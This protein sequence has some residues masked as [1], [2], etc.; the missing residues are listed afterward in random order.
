LPAHCW[1]AA[2]GDQRAAS[3]ARQERP[4]SDH[5]APR[6]RGVVGEGGLE[7]PAPCSQSRCATTAPLPVGKPGGCSHFYA[8]PEGAS[9]VRPALRAL[10]VA[11]PLDSVAYMRAVVEPLEG[12]KVKLSIEVD[13]QEFEKDIDAA[14]RQ[15]A[16]EV[17]IPGFRPGKAPRRILE[18]RLG[19]AA[20]RSEALRQA[21]PTYYSKAI[22]EHDVDVVAAPQIEITAGQD[23][24][25]VVFDAVVEVRPHVAVTGYEALRVTIPSPV[26]TPEDVEA[27]IDRLRANFAELQEVSRP[28]RAGDFVSLN[29]Q[30]T[31]NEE[32]VAGLSADDFLYEIGSG[33]LLPQLDEKLPGVRIGDILDFEA[34]LPD[35][36]PGGP[37]RMKVLV[38][39]V[40][41]RK[42]PDLDDE[43]ASEASEFD[44]VE[45]LR[46]DI[47]KRTAVMK[48][49]QAAMA[50]RNAVVE[51]LVEL[52]KE[53]P[54]ET[55]V[56]AEVER[57]AHDLVHRLER[58]GNDVSEYLAATGQS[59]QELLEG[60]RARA[61]PAV[62]ADLALRAVAEAEG[63][64]PTEEDLEAELQRLAGSYGVSAVELRAS[65]ERSD[66]MP[67]L[68][69]DWKKAK[70]L[71]WLVEHV[72]VVDEAGNPI[73][74]A[75]LVLDD[76]QTD[77]GETSQSEAGSQGADDSP[78]AEASEPEQRQDPTSEAEEAQK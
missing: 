65:L 32:P 69:S 1:Q 3:E 19:K 66:Q 5:G 60:F 33:S 54:P 11:L 61:I 15:I 26:A 49:L 45:E 38:K 24:G 31:Q 9:S 10:G 51:G 78:K 28:A 37:V 68:R 7:P 16:R 2:R 22:R 59:A 50:L 18:A 12:N 23:D 70:A 74:R 58:Q 34:E 42:L 52:V 71:E 8:T 76:D 44:T 41:E 40:K 20:G 30:A 47:A 57:E 13:E 73:D 56:Q 17:R 35:Q 48:K 29:L 46:A 67:A 25:P 43:W 36:A 6:C 55:L 75:L 39:G 64:E 63:F 4:V 14:F 77:S 27:Q 53:D 72:E 62:K 21:L